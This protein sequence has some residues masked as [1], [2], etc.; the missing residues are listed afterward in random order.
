MVVGLV[1]CLV[2]VSFG[3]I[4]FLVVVAVAFFGWLVAFFGL[5]RLF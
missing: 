5:V 4:F 1:R 3:L 2:L